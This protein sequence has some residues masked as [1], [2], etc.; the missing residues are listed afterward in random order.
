M[1]DLM[2]AKIRI[3]T[4]CAK[5]DID[6]IAVVKRNVEELK[7]ILSKPSECKDELHEYEKRKTT[8]GHSITMSYF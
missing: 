4:I 5:L 7:T 8:T 1:K 6:S 2:T 3:R